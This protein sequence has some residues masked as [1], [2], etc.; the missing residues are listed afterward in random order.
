MMTDLKTALQEQQFELHYQ[1]QIDAA[2]GAITGME[3][4][5]RWFHPQHGLIPPLKFIP[6][7]EEIG[8]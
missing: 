7:A 6:I 2:S 1:P 8:H 3:S 4:L 5:I